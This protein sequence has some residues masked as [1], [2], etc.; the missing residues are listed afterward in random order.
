MR[1]CV[2]P[3]D[4]YDGDGRFGTADTEGVEG[5]PAS[6]ASIRSLPQARRRRTRPLSGCRARSIAASA[7]RSWYR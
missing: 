2:L 6:T 5:S 1:A 4:D 3:E 7:R